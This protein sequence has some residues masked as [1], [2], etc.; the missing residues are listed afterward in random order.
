MFATRGVGVPF[1]SAVP[2]ASSCANSAVR[3]ADGSAS[4]SSAATPAA[5]GAAAGRRSFA[6]SEH[7]IKSYAALANLLEDEEVELVVVATPSSSHAEVAIQA[8]RAGKHVVVEKP[9]CMNAAEADSMIKAARRAKRTLT[10]FQN[11][12]WDGH[13]RTALK[14]ARSGR[15]GKIWRVKLVSW[16]YSDIMLRYGVKEFRPQ[17]R[18]EAEWGGGVLYDF[19]AH[20]LDQLLQLVPERA[21]RVYGRLEN[22]RWSEDADDGFFCELTFKNGAVAQV[23][24]VVSSYASMHTGWVISGEK[25]GYFVDAEG[26]KI[27]TGSPRAL[28]TKPVKEL[29]RAWEEF[30]KNLRAHIRRRK[31]LAVRPEEVRRVMF[32]MDALRKSS[33]RGRPV[34]LSRW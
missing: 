28:R 7:G 24:Y 10:V 12:R 27:V 26:P 31:G 30:Y 23:E 25:G 17:W 29:P 5:C 22:L 2:R 1:A 3:L 20:T 6:E 32:V 14:V 15:L 13:F 4:R 18:S 9:M 8:L 21:V 16:D 34:E 19:G 11:R 33:R